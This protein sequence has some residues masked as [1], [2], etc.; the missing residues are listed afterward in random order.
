MSNSKSNSNDFITASYYIEGVYV[1]PA[2]NIIIENNV[3]LHIQPKVMEV[4]TYL[5]SKAEQL[6]S[7]EEL[8]NSCWSNQYISDGAV[9]KCIAQIRK[10]LSDDP[11]KPH[12]IKTVPKKGYVFI[13][14][15]KGLNKAPQPIMS[16]WTGESPY[17]GLKPFTFAQSDIFFGR[18]QVIEE[19]NNWVSQLDEKDTAWLSLAAPVGAGKSSLVYA[20]LLPML[21]SHSF[22]STVH[23]EFCNVV[24]L[25]SVVTSQKLHVYLLEMLLKK[26][27][28][29]PILTLQDY[30]T[31]ITDY[32]ENPA[33]SQQI[34]LFQSTLITGKGHSRFVLF[35]DH[36]EMLFDPYSTLNISQEEQTYFF[37]LLQ[38]LVHSKECF[39]ITTIREQFLTA[40]VQTAQL[41]VHAFQY[42]IPNFSHTELID[43][44][45]KPAEFSGIH[46]EYNGENR[47]RLNSVIIHQL[48][49]DFLPIAIVQYLL[50][51]LYAEKF[52]QIM[53]YKAYN[54]MGGIAGC[55]VTIAEQNYQKLTVNEQA[56]FE[57]ILLRILTLDAGGQIVKSEQCCFISDLT[58]KTQLLVIHQFINVGIFQ[59]TCLN[60]QIGIRLAHD[61]LLESWPRI[62]LWIKAN[63][64]K[65]YLRYDLKIATQRWLYH[66]QSSHLLIHSNQKIKKIN[67][68]LVDNDF[69]LSADEKCLI[70]L[71]VN[72]L[73]RLNRVKKATI[74][75]FFIS[76]LSL[77]WLS[78]SLIQKNEEVNT[79]RNNAENLISFILF[80]L[81]DK[82]QPLGKLELLNIVADKALNYFELAG[83]ENLTGKALM[84][85]TESLHILGEVNISKNNFTV[86]ESYF[87]QTEA[88]L[89]Y[90]LQKDETN[91]KLL[92]LY[93][94]T[95]YWLGYS[96]FLQVD[97][98]AA[99]P[100]FYQYLTYADILF[101]LYPKDNWHLEKSY[102]LNNLG[103]LAEKNNQ[104][105]LASDYFEQSALIKLALLEKQPNN[106]V[107]RSD[108]AGTRSW[109]SN[110]KAKSGQ[111]FTAIDYLKE[112]LSQVNKINSVDSSFKNIE[113]ISSFEHKIAKLYYNAG[114]LDNSNN[115]TFK[116]QANLVK[117]VNNDEDNYRFK[118]DL[119][120]SHVLSVQLFINQHKLDQ[121]LIYIDKAR[122]LVN[123][124]NNSAKSTSDLMHAN[125]SILQFQA[126]A[127]FLLQQQQSALL[128][129]KEAIKFFK[130]HLSVNNQA[131]L[132]AS[133]MLTKLRILKVIGKS[134]KAALENEVLEIES[135]L[136]SKLQ[137]DT[138]DY[139]VIS[140]YLTTLKFAL[141]FTNK[142][143]ADNVWLKLYQRSDYNIPDYSMNNAIVNIKNINE[144]NKNITKEKKDK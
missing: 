87:K 51:G 59:L 107:I 102:A 122:T 124:L 6:V 131:S 46:F 125:V 132:Y 106:S 8:I 27:K 82:L 78:V 18:E 140:M 135:L 7:S 40:L 81:K 54:K 101:S 100:F 17:P 98:K 1:D 86:A 80:D 26:E 30:E 144:K 128:A 94:L 2:Q 11:K 42:Q 130:Q 50:S 14:K 114:D 21:M 137:E 75:T 3:T 65:L 9:H 24:D 88:A 117:L 115:Y 108:L 99:E 58:D 44:V 91:E 47:E 76:F 64:S 143:Q 41:D 73:K 55:F 133:L 85:W 84:Q 103:S 141:E 22:I 4:L 68:I 33:D 109:Q 142:L 104:L 70:T 10:A 35:I 48:H 13:A 134:D 37:R 72:K 74:A 28:L 32:I 43:I 45:E 95:N 71:S 60:N 96:A 121:A 138:P 34:A 16:H 79:T 127:M 123:L 110:I 12:F 112:A 15:I 23:H 105:D 20:G 19:I 49:V 89:K 126:Q 67:S 93:M 57:R 92:E 61:S 136:E 116:A 111:L 118:E 129:I 120:W 29:S 97:Y 69:T 56:S 25:A 62:S 38:L 53:T 139:K 119:L 36:L 83:T 63:I 90:A 5:C 77:S 66:E 31:I 52:N 39:L 113:L